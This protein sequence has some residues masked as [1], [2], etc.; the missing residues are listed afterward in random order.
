MNE[1]FLVLISLKAWIKQPIDLLL[2]KGRIALWNL[3]SN[4]EDMLCSGISDIHVKELWNSGKK[5]I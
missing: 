3:E 5:L 2:I 4:I 1:D